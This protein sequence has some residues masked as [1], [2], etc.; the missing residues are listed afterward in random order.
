MLTLFAAPAAFAQTV[1]IDL[2]PGVGSLLRYR[3][4]PHLERGLRAAANRDEATA[5][6]EL[7]HARRLAPDNAAVAAYLADAY[8]TFGRIAEARALLQDQL[9][10]TPRETR[11]SDALSALA[12]ETGQQANRQTGQQQPSTVG[13]SRAPVARP[14]PAPPAPREAPAVSRNA[15]PKSERVIAERPSSLDAYPRGDGLE[16]Y[17][18]DVGT[19][20]YRAAELGFAA[21]NA[22][23]YVEA[24]REFERAWQLNRSSLLVASQLVYVH[25]RLANN[26]RARWFAEQVIDAPAT[27]PE[28]RFALMR[29]HEDLGRR[30]TLSVD[31]FSGAGAA[32]TSVS[33]E[34]R[35][36]RSYAQ[37]E[38]DLRLGNPPIRNG[39]T[40]SLYA[41]LFADGGIRNL[42]VPAANATLGAGLR[43]KPFGN[44]V[45]FLM[46]EAQGT[47]AQGDGDLLVRTSASL[48]N[49][50]RWS[51]DWHPSGRGWLARN[52]YLDAGY[53][54][55]SQR[56]AMAA[57]YRMSYHRRLRGN[58][59]LEPFA[60]L[61]VNGFR[62]VRFERDLR[63]G[64]GARWNLWSGER[65][66]DAFRHKMSAGIEFQRGIDTYL[67]GRNGIF[68]S[69][70]L[71][72]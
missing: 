19:L 68:V 52:L 53:Y 66:Y 50:G 37:A 43:W 20:A 51:D 5:I 48:F 41:R 71:R 63:V 60:R 4:Y 16:P 26:E 69:A 24:E 29:L 38:A 65:R 10:K 21:W 7:E 22:G 59:S 33:R 9:R 35:A 58:Q 23:D 44:R 55:V 18:Q 14:A 11:L 3:L 62:D 49:S 8:R 25:Q 36:F 70:G 57:D 13:A 30:V 40:L 31:G 39:S 72:R 27:E 61:Q 56:F 45:F 12:P 64:I 32:T 54:A 1:A 46:A 2:G 67:P 42:A 34:G 6:A 47:P 17:G 15:E 28:P